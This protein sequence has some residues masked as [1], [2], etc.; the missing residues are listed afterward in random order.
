MSSIGSV[1]ILKQLIPGD[2]HYGTNLLVEFDPDSIWFET[3]LWIAADALRNGLKTAYHTW[4]RPPSAIREIL[5]GLSGLD[6]PKLEE[7]DRLRIPDSYSAQTGLGLADPS[8]SKNREKPQP[9]KISDL[10][11]DAVQQIKSHAEADKRWLHI[12]DNN[13]V[14]VQYN[15]EKAVIDH[16]RTRLIPLC[17]A[18]GLA[19]VHSLAAGIHSSSF[20]KQFELF[21]DGIIDF[22]SE[23]KGDR[24]E[25]FV[26]VRMMRGRTYDSRWRRLRLLDNGE[27]TLAE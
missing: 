11:I 1:A 26:R 10:S 16:Y 4:T 3:S 24:I 2:I 7:E 27:V 6:I 22:K 15:E 25:Q 17:K 18:R 23:E 5:S 21:C 13:S 12:D 8:L 19:A 9:L 20:Y 14:L